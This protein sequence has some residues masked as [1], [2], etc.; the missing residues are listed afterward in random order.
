MKARNPRNKR[1]VLLT[2]E[3]RVGEIAELLRVR[4]QT[5]GRWLNNGRLRSRAVQD[6]ILF[7]KNNS[8]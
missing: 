5:V 2:D 1:Q 7:V 8:D 6:V 4:R 3:L